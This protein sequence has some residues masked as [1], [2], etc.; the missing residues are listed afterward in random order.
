[1]QIVCGAT[2]ETVLNLWVT[3]AGL[4]GQETREM[5]ACFTEASHLYSNTWLLSCL[6]K[7]WIKSVDRSCKLLW[8]NANSPKSLIQSSDTITKFRTKF[9][10]WVRVQNFNCLPHIYCKS[11]K[12]CNQKFTK[13]N[14]GEAK[15]VSLQLLNWLPHDSFYLLIPIKCPNRIWRS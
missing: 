4:L 3:A 7:Y 15:F 1:M 6:R 13:S 9:Q 11:I 12:S 5:L 14:F 8:F 2:E 10:S